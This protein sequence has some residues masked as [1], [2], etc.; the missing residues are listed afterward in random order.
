M[1][2]AKHVPAILAYAPRTVR[3]QGRRIS[4]TLQTNR[5]VRRLQSVVNILKTEVTGDICASAQAPFSSI[6]KN[7]CFARPPRAL[8]MVQEWAADHSAELMHNWDIARLRKPLNPVE[9]LG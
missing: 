9:P 8:K 2:A 6:R 7:D 1:D 4:S 5:V 3:H